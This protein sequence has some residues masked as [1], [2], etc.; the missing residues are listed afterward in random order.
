M[1]DTRP[2]CSSTFRIVG[3]RRAELTADVRAHTE[4]CNACGRELEAL[5]AMVRAGG[6][7]DNLAL[8]PART[9]RVRMMILERARRRPES[10]RVRPVLWLGAA[11][12]VLLAAA[13]WWSSRSDA[14]DAATDPVALHGTV[15]ASD[16]S[17]FTHTSRYPDEVVRLTDGGITVAVSPLAP[18]ERFRVIVGDAEVEVRGTAFDVVASDDRLIEVS[19]EHGRVEVRVDGAPPVVLDAGER[20]SRPDLTIADAVPEEGAALQIDDVVQDELPAR[21]TTARER[22]RATSDRDAHDSVVGA[23]EAPVAEPTEASA[24]AAAGRDFDAGWMALRSGDAERAASIFDEVVASDPLAEDARFWRG[25]ALSRCGHAAESRQAFATFL[26]A[27]PRSSRRAEVAVMLGWLLIES[28]DRDGARARFATASDDSNE[29]VRT[30]AR[31]GLAR[32]N[33]AEGDER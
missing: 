32:L 28:G 29:R 9:E 2:V 23:S 19:V 10:R 26:E 8:A 3:K 14:G 30:S 27:F 33:D 25:V 21:R 31:R 1:T 16:G 7:S 20:W 17:R 18:N 24:P 22:A 5:E 6:A 11:A 12:A 15:S 13:G 4:S